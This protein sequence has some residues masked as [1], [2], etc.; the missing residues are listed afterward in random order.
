M[1]RIYLDHN[2]TTRPLPEVVEA[3]TACLRDGFGNPS[4]VH[5]F[6]QSARRLLDRAREQVAT[7]LNASPEEILFT[8][9]GTEADNQALRCGLEHGGSLVTSVIEHPA[10]LNTCRFLE[11]KGTRVTYLPVD[12]QG[13][14]RLDTLGG[15]LEGAS[16][17]S[18]M[19][20]NNDLGTLQPLA[21]AAALA[22]TQGVLVHTDAVQAAGRIPLDVRTLGVDLLS[23]SAHKLHGPKGVGALFVRRA[24]PLRPL[25][26][27][28]SQER[29]LRAGTE[30]LPGIVGFGVAC[31]WA[32]QRMDANCEGISALRVRL[33]EGLLS[34]PGFRLHGHP[35]L[36]LPNT[37][38]VGLPGILGA[39]L[40]LNL[41][42][43]G[44]AVSV[45]SA[46]SSESREPSYVLKALGIPDLEARQT[47]RFSLGFENT[48]AEISRT[49]QVTREIVQRLR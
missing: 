28:G 11:A 36:R 26:Q 14:L 29:R 4:S 6:G 27:G 39:D 16:L 12:E 35:A 9:G 37:V 2:A 48:E 31:E 23:L 22:R 42:L 24:L 34:I 41:D 21:E 1:D 18:L 32:R 8:S 49:I 46:C 20:A 40:L 3:M 5:A 25:I 30:N 10:I 19:A 33:E 38:N 15:A 47:L 44:I 43:E 45:G 17:L 7:L 13:I